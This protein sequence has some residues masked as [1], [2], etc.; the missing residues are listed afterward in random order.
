[1]IPN[2][3]SIV[4]TVVAAAVTGFFSAGLGVWVAVK[5]TARDVIWLKE[6]FERLMGEMDEFRR[7]NKQS[8]ERVH[9]RIDKHIEH[10]HTPRGMRG[11]EG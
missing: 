10:Y 7:D 2:M 8:L 3:E 11:G 6:L 1:M 5:L 4:T 9:T